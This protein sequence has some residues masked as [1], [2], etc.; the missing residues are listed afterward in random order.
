MI[1]KCDQIL[2]GGRGV[3]MGFEDIKRVVRMM[4]AGRFA[5]MLEF[6]RTLLHQ[7]LQGWLF[8]ASAVVY[9]LCAAV[10]VMGVR[11]LGV[12]LDESGGFRV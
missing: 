7:A 5:K 11:L 10:G 1:R 12:S 4:E 9:I 8:K 6:K 3:A 2:L